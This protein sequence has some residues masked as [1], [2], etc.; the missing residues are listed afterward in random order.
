MSQPGQSDWF[1]NS[2]C[3]VCLDSRGHTGVGMEEERMKE[4]VLCRAVW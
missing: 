4:S 3:L 1:V 2:L